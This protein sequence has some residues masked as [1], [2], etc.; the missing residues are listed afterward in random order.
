MRVNELVKGRQIKR[1]LMSERVRE[2]VCVCL[3]KRERERERE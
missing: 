1:G 2:I 3:C